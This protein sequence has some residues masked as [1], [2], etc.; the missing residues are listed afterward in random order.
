MYHGNAGG[1]EAKTLVKTKIC[2]ISLA[3]IGCE[4]LEIKRSS[5]S[6]LNLISLPSRNSCAFHFHGK[7]SVGP[8]F[9]ER[10]QIHLV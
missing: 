7:C 9:G 8:G 5:S 6:A 4:R 2:V 1:V 10:I 3:H